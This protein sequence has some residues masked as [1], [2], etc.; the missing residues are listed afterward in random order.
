VEWFLALGEE[1]DGTFTSEGIFDYS[2]IWLCIG[3]IV[4][5]LVQMKK[6]AVRLISGDSS[7][8][9]HRLVAVP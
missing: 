5:F 6:S 4:V 7:R 8:K 2:G 3:L 9:R 1:K